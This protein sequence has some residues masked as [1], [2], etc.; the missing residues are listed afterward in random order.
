MHILHT[1]ASKGLGGQELRTLREAEGM[2]ARGHHIVFAVQ[3]GGQ[4]VQKAREAGFTVYELDWKRRR[5]FAILMQ[6][7]AIVKKEKVEIINTHSSVDGWV[8]GFCGR[9]L[10]CKIIRTRH[11]STPIRAGL[12]SRLLYKS[13][14]DRVVTTCQDVAELIQRQAGLTPYGCQ[15]IPTGIISENLKVNE[16]DRQTFRQRYGIQDDQIVIG[17]LCVMRSW[18]GIEDLLAAAAE[19]KD[20]KRLK[21]LMVGDGPAKNYFEDVMTRHGL[22]ENVIFAGYHPNPAAALAAMDIFALVSRSHEGVSQAI[23][24]AGYLKKPLIATLTGGL[25]EVCLNGETGFTV[26]TEAPQEI[27]KKVKS[28][29]DNP[30]LSRKMGERAHQHVCDHFTMEKTLDAMESIYRSFEKGHVLP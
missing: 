20:D 25:S 14:A 24:Q 7:R 9:M 15:S 4:L 21:W 19:L 13:L 3:E 29:A 18:K 2:R 26:D 27:A 30:E 28:L 23:L 6:L 22:G 8:G 11:L 16:G 12:N 5:T 1:E 10:G 17:T